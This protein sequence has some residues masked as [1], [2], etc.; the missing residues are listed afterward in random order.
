[1][2]KKQGT[3]IYIEQENLTEAEF[4]SRSFV[5]KE[6]KNRAY[7][8]AL[9]AELVM[10]YFASEGVDVENLH[11]MH[12]ISKILEKYDI[13]DILLPNIHIDVR[14]VFD[15]NQIFI[16]KSHFEN[17]MVPSVYAILKLDSEF[18]TVEFLGYVKPSQINK[19]NQN[20]DYYFVSR[21]RLS[22]TVGFVGFIKNFNSST[23][24]NISEEDFLLGRELSVA[25]NDHNISEEEQQKLIELLLISDSLRESVLEFDNFETLSYSAA[26]DLAKTVGEIDFV[27]P[28]AD[29]DTQDTQQ[30]D[31]IETIQEDVQ[32]DSLVLS[33]EEFDKL[34]QIE[35]NVG[36]TT[37]ELDE[38]V[39]NDISYE[40]A[41][42]EDISE[43]ELSIEENDLITEQN[44]IED[45]KDSELENIPENIEIIDNLNISE[46]DLNLSETENLGSEIENLS[47]EEFTSETVDITDETISESNLE[48]QDLTLPETEVLDEST[49]SQDDVLLVGKQ[50]EN[51]IDEDSEYKPETLNYN[52]NNFSVDALLDEKIAQIDE[53]KSKPE[54]SLGQ[55][56]TEALS[57]SIETGISGAATA[58]QLGTAATAASAIAG[59]G[60]TAATIDAAATVSDQAIKLASVA[61]DT[62][63]D[64]LDK[65]IEKQSEFKDNVNADNFDLDVDASAMPQDLSVSDIDI[66]SNNIQNSDDLFDETMNLSDL[67]VVKKDFD[68]D[69]FDTNT[70]DLDEIDTINS[71]ILKQ[72]A[73]TDTDT[74]FLD[75]LEKISEPKDEFLQVNSISEAE[76]VDMPDSGPYVIEEDS[77]ETIFEP[78]L[79]NNVI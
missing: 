65:N 57:K 29:E 78:D 73:K 77:N 14:V 33:D 49:I 66:E 72:N 24:V 7:L 44:N 28:V 11:N 3:L 60:E 74:Q 64:I 13:S 47:Q 63:E 20:E 54:K 22:A 31:E 52:D 61:G 39:E 18:K 68:D 50:P 38:A 2:V 53:Q 12:S 30:S 36:E 26:P 23:S 17:N 70:V 46:Q 10:K 4:M 8:N 32:E 48:V 19:N 59:V 75:T 25:L 27:K 76:V 34:T 55:T 37:S 41:A 1:M 67:Y 45:S 79:M 56:I 15:E 9:G 62:I 43:E 5:N 71:D 58:A 35:E 51:T 40:K 16:P 69:L 6:V 21:N 42:E